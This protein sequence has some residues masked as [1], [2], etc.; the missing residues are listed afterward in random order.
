M[1]EVTV[2]LEIV[3]DDEIPSDEVRDATDGEIAVSDEADGS[4]DADN[5]VTVTDAGAVVWADEATEITIEEDSVEI[6]GEDVGGVAASETGAEETEAAVVV[7]E[8]DLDVG[9]E[10][11]NA[12]TDD[13][14]AE[15]ESLEV[16]S[17]TF[18]DFGDEL[19]VEDELS[20]AEDEEGEEL[21]SKDEV[22]EVRRTV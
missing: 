15:T 20:V 21:S 19:V 17:W 12:G 9:T 18:D 13:S 8:R 1:S 3:T 11:L 2:E 4:I 22:C 6:A 10:E 7:V 14:E 16:G 5:D